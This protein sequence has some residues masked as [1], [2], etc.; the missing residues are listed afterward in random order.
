V[1]VWRKKNYFMNFELFVE[2]Q[3]VLLL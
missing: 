2:R 3:Y 1:F